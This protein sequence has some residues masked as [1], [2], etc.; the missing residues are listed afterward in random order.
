MVL[1]C[2]R[3]LVFAQSGLLLLVRGNSA[4]FEPVDSDC[5]AVPAGKCYLNTVESTAE[6]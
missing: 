3:S 2:G 6:R 1:K 4:E 5:W